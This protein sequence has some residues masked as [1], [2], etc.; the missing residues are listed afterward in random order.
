MKEG[1]LHELPGGWVWTRLESCIEILD[2]K[3]VPINAEER[4]K[5]IAGKATSELYPYYGA[6]G[7]VG[8]IDDFLLDEELILLPEIPS[9]VGYQISKLRKSTSCTTERPNFSTVLFSLFV[10]YESFGII[11]YM[12]LFFTKRSL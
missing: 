5:R 9:F 12:W 1:A 7:Q 8:W 6:T 4:K 3:R 11:K 2:S 10:D